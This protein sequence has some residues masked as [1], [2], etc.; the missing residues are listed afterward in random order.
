[1]VFVEVQSPIKE[2]TGWRRPSLT[3]RPS[4][5]ESSPHAP[6]SGSII[7]VRDQGVMNWKYSFTFRRAEEDP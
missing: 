7:K 6:V 4:E 5:L 1:M 2:K 3:S